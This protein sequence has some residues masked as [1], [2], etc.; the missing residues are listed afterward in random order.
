VRP[1]GDGGGN[2]EFLFK[3]LYFC[4][5]MSCA[6][7]LCVATSNNIASAAAARHRAATSQQAT[8]IECE[9]SAVAASRGREYI[10]KASDS[11]AA[12]VAPGHDAGRS[13]QH[14]TENHFSPNRRHPANLVFAV[15]HAA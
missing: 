6:M 11:I 10:N 15:S 2:I 5:V 14:P 9:A 8:A 3:M 1:A 4:D 13:G 12:V 7:L